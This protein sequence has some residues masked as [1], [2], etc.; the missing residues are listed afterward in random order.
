MLATH[1][2]LSGL[3]K[4][5]RSLM[6]VPSI[7]QGQFGGEA[8]RLLDAGKF[9]THIN[10][11][12][13]RE[14]RIA[15]YKDPETHIAVMTHQA[16]RDD[17][18]H[19]S[20]KHH[21]ISEGEMTKKL[22]GM[23]TAE[24]KQWA[25][26]TMQKEGIN[27]DASFVDEAHDTLNRA[28]KDNSG[29]S[30]VIE[31]VGHNTPYHVYAS[32]DP[33]KND[34]SEIH[35]MLQKMD[36]E[37]YSD[38]AEFMRKY[39][40]DTISSKQ[41]LKREMARYV[42][43]TAIT[44]DVA[45]SRITEKVQLSAGQ[46]QALSDL[47]YHL[48]RAKSARATGSIDIESAKAISPSSFDGAPE[49]QHEA[50]AKTI[51]NSLGVIKSSAVNRIINTHP[52]NAKVAHAVEMVKQR[53]GKQGVIFAR[54]KDSVEQY[55]KAMEAIGKKVVTITGADSGKDKDAKRKL[56]NP[57]KGEAQAD[58][59]IASD[60]GAVG[61]NLQSGH[62]LI[63]HDIPATAKTHSQRQARID[64]IGQKNSIELIDLHGDHAEERKSHSRLMRKYD[65]KNMMADPMDG[66]DDTG[67]AGAIS[68]RKK[69]A[70]AGGSLL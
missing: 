67:I 15:A 31:A 4:A 57:E 29:L 13:S 34:P 8:L 44:P 62:Y 30:N 43:P 41:A 58:I 22:Q 11:S 68:H 2:H 27:F 47:S 24:R 14:E 19:L 56:F 64:R 3:G 33:V 66:L 6:L 21:G 39:G 69:L 10:P 54:N 28:G 32:G 70:E 52:D 38:R 12:A 20:A 7:V 51:Q 23:G 35:S 40:A 36:P 1:A 37:R 25:A 65:L 48:G 59:L 42:F 9:K 55:R 5:K 16:F 53:E 50:I 18:I 63:Q 26:D 46:Q 45:R 49:E 61:M 60:A 17:M